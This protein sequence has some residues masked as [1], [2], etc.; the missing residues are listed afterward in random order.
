MM[1]QMKSVRPFA[2][3]ML[4]S[5]VSVNWLS[6]RSVMAAAAVD[7]GSI[8]GKVTAEKGAVHAVRVR[9]KDTVRKIAYTVFTR[10]GRYQ[11]Y[12]LP[13]GSYQVLALQ[14]GFKSTTQSVELGSGETK[15]ADVALTGDSGAWVVQVRWKLLRSETD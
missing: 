13:P 8:S 5:L 2:L 9:A 15:T 11:I 4:V 1:S 3:L 7:S 6:E 14:D 12:N 10:N